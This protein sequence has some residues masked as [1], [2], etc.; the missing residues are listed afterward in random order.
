MADYAQYAEQQAVERQQAGMPLSAQEEMWIEQAVSNPLEAAYAALQHG[1]QQLYNGL[2]ERIAAENPAL[3]VNVGTQAQMAFQQSQAQQRVQADAQAARAADFPTALGESVGRVG[4]DLERY[5]PQMSEKIGELGEY[6]PYVQTIMHTPDPGQ[7]DLA[8]MAVYDLVRTG[9]TSV[10][11]A[12]ETEREAQI[13]KEAEMRREAA[14][15]ITGSPHASTPKQSP[16]LQA[17]ED[18]WRRAGQWHD[19]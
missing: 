12:K 4:I 6:H 8:M 11:R 7:R 17:M 18:E 13:R 19:E 14:S 1:N 2:I 10:T 9:T 3:A 15:V 5:G 16:F